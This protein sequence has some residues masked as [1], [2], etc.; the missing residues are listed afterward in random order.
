MIYCSCVRR[1]SLDCLA[2]RF[3]LP[4][5]VAQYEEAGDGCGC[6]RGCHPGYDDAAVRRAG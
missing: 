6:D 1:D 4:A 2:R 3:A 5:V